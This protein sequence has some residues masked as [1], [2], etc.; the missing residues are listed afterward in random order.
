MRKLIK[1][2]QV[3]TSKP[4]TEVGSR[5]KT[6]P[7]LFGNESSDEELFDSTASTMVKSSDLES[8]SNTVN[9]Q[10]P[11]S[12]GGATVSQK[13]NVNN[14]SSKDN[15]EL[16]NDKTDN[17]AVGIKELPSFN[18]FNQFEPSDKSYFED[19]RMGNICDRLV[20]NISE[21]E[22]EIVGEK[23]TIATEDAPKA[24]TGTENVIP[25]SYVPDRSRTHKPEVA[26]PAQSV[27][28][29][30]SATSNLETETASNPVQNKKEGILMSPM[31]TR[32]EGKTKSASIDSPIPPENVMTDDNQQTTIS[33]DDSVDGSIVSKSTG[34][35]KTSFIKD[36]NRSLAKFPG[37]E[38]SPQ[39]VWSQT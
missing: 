1:K 38:S 33:R 5:P 20:E 32:S 2:E 14:T 19:D 6:K 21:P 39:Q 24:A 31:L 3:S 17:N 7:S 23:I 26:K 34:K 27:G 9:A 25:Q 18:K 37:A 22:Q 16:S 10:D 30:K 35:F 29:E 12:S 36:L 13:Q 11:S 8:G 28:N 15:K 4:K